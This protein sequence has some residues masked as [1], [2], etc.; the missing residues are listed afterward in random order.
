[1]ALS[2][3]ILYTE[4][5]RRTSRIA[6]AVSHP[7]RLLLLDQLRDGPLEFC[8]LLEDHPL[9]QSALSQHLRWLRS[10]NLVQCNCTGKRSIY[11]LLPENHPTW[12][13]Q[14]LTNMSSNRRYPQAA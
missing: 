6:K 8:Q 4:T 13:T 7:A 14:I 3:A 12:L 10:V 11:Q 1:M 5:N 2:K 9:S